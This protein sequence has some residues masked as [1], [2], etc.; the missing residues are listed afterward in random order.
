MKKELD[1]KISN[2]EA[3]VDELEAKD[4]G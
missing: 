2:L 3:K 1:K 4:K